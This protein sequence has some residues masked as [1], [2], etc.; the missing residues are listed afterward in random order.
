MDKA[1]AMF[2]LY[3]ILYYTA[4]P[5][6]FPDDT[7]TPKDIVVVEEVEKPKTVDERKV[8]LHQ[9]NRTERYTKTQ[10]TAFAFERHYDSGRRGVCRHAL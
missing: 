2:V 5:Y 8:F 4:G 3:A 6:V 1:I 7:Y 9:L 10:E